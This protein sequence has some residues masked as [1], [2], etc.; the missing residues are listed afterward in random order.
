MEPDRFSGLIKVFEDA[1]FAI[2]QPDN[3]FSW[4]GWTDEAAAMAEVNEILA[5]LR[6]GKVPDRLQMEVLFA[7]TGPLQEL[8]LSS[9]WADDFL[10]LAARFDRELER[11]R[12]N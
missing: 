3:D 5:K 1:A 11:S 12:K 2:S 8:S 6:T 7:P 9:G 4:S 10:K